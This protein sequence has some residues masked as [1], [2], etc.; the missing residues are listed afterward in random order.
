VECTR[1]P[2]CAASDMELKFI[3]IVIMI[4]VGGY[5]GYRFFSTIG[6]AVG[7]VFSVISGPF[8]MASHLAGTG[9]SVVNDGVNDAENVADD[10]GHIL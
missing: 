7:S 1:I 5:F 2:R 4:G 8:T 10:I 6:G 9:L 3:L